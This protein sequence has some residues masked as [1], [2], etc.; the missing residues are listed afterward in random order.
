[1]R[2]VAPFPEAI[3]LYWKSYIKQ[4]QYHTIQ[5]HTFGETTGSGSKISD[6]GGLAAMKVWPGSLTK[7]LLSTT[8]VARA[9][10]QDVYIV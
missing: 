1:M 2:G 4:L 9:D 8:I 10:F 5:A 3:F 7:I 6:V